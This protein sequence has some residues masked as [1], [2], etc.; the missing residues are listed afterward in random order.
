LAT[1]WLK[2]VGKTV[3]AVEAEAFRY[4]HNFCNLSGEFNQDSLF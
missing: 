3:H 1:V 2:G 4:R